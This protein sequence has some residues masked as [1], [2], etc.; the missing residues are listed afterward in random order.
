MLAEVFDF[1]FL[2]TFSGRIRVVLL[3]RGRVVVL[4]GGQVSVVL[5]DGY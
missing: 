2:G 1:I 3:Y 5:V 4:G